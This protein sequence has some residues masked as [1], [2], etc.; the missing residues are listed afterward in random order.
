MKKE[1]I[2]F[3]NDF[4]VMAITEKLDRVEN[5]KRGYYVSNGS[6]SRNS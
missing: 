3:F 1:K 4:V 6:P 5:K 2:L